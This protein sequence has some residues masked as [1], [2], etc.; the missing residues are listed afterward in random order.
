M[1]KRRA[2]QAQ[3][4]VDIDKFE[5]SQNLSKK[6]CK[7]ISIDNLSEK[8]SLDS[9][10]AYIAPSDISIV[11]NSE[12]AT[13]ETE[14][15][16]SIAANT[17]ELQ[18][19]C[20]TEDKVPGYIKSVNKPKS[21]QS[22]PMADETD[23]EFYDY[24]S[25]S[26]FDA[27]DTDVYQD[28]QQSITDIELDATEEIDDFDTIPVKPKRKLYEVE[29]KSLDKNELDKLKDESLSSV[30]SI[31]SLVPSQA[32][33]LLQYYKWNK[34]KL[35]EEYSDSEDA[36]KAGLSQTESHYEPP[37]P[38]KVDNYF[39]SICCET[40]SSVLVFSLKCN[41]D[42]CLNCYKTYAETKVSDFGDWRVKCPG[43]PCNLVLDTEMMEDL[44]KPETL[45]KYHALLHQ[46]YYACFPK[47]HFC[48][49]PDCSSA[50]TCN[51]KPE[52]L[53]R[54]VP[55][56]KCSNG[57]KF[58]YGC[59][60]VDHQPSTCILVKKWLK[61]C[62]DDSETANWISAHTKECVKCRTTIEKNGGCNHM[63]CKKCKH[64]FCWVC[65]GPWK[66]HGTNYYNC[67]RYDEK[68]GIDARDVQAK[69]RASLKRYLHYYNRFMNHQQSAK[70]ERELFIRT[71]QKMTDL[72]V[73]TDM[74]WI[75]VQFLQ[76]AID[77][78]IDCRWTLKWT[79]A[80]A[81]Y[82]D[83]RDN[84]TQIFEDNQ[85]DLEIAVE[86]L[87][88]LCEQPIE[89]VRD[90]QKLKQ[91]VLDKTVYVSTRREVL[92]EDTAKGLL[93]GRWVYNI[94]LDE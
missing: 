70:L 82:L 32:Y 27:N 57:H 47:I 4:I 74:T 65:M 35:L 84:N 8:D 2:S 79:Y 69:S 53:N 94:G 21:H 89:A 39:C 68:S 81:F 26:S 67:N 58:C 87:S 1:A 3:L 92:L 73:Q 18:P 9:E 75:E 59:E 91:S 60:E 28:D 5:T 77:V 43:N 63:I 34:E 76:R 11:Q 80:F 56:V 54:I 31:F 24:C 29:Y 25:Q 71:Q 85:A 22:L 52:E 14:S 15:C 30:T 72:Q 38:K 10:V 13:P 64:E 17:Q 93:E 78:L 33:L 6:Q 51:I 40:Y 44:L 50:V 36:D 12:I 20:F 86:Q 7:S 48:I 41:H 90:L 16:T 83:K 49:F 46:S 23:D 55:T 62:K 45:V 37:K 66:E 88:E 19:S 61:K 42:F